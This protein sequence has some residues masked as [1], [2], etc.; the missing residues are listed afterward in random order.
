MTIKMWSPTKEDDKAFEEWIDSQ[1]DP[2]DYWPGGM[3]ELPEVDDPESDSIPEWVEKALLAVPIEELLQEQKALDTDPDPSPKPGARRLRR[4][5][6][7]GEGAAK[8]GWGTDG[9]YMR[10]VSHLGKYVTDPKG[11]CNVYHQAALG[12]PPG[13]GH[14]DGEGDDMETR[15]RVPEEMKDL[16]AKSSE[17]ADRMEVKK[18]RRVRTRAGA[19][20]YK[21]PI[22]SVI[23]RDAVMS[24]LK[25]EKPV[26]DGFDTVTGSNGKK[27]DLGKDD[28]G[29]WT[30][31]HHDSNRK[32]AVA[33]SEED[34]F[35]AVN[36]K[37]GR[38]GSRRASKVPVESSPNTPR[39]GSGKVP[40]SSRAARE[41]RA[42]R[43]PIGN[44]SG[45]QMARDENRREGTASL[46]SGL[47]GD[48]K[49]ASSYAGEKASLNLPDGRRLNIAESMNDEGYDV[50]IDNPKN[51]D[52]EML[53]EGVSKARAKGVAKSH[54]PKSSSSASS[55]S[56]RRAQG[57]LDSTLEASNIRI[58]MHARGIGMNRLQAMSDEDVDA[59]AKDT[60]AS[61]ATVRS[62]MRSE[63]RRRL[64][65]QK[66][67]A[68]ERVSSA[69]APVRRAKEK[70]D[71]ASFKRN[72]KKGDKVT[73]KNSTASDARTQDAVIARVGK[74][75][76][77][78]TDAE[79][80]QYV[81]VNIFEDRSSFTVYEEDFARW[82]L[83]PR[84]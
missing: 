51:D 14:K 28:A 77:V 72:M 40:S 62:V 50:F 57:N 19:A 46:H 2:S 4:Y 75:K 12:A 6:T 16:L 31:F 38:S 20:W 55:S 39:D 5:W 9:D 7:R 83:R 59:L 73:I 61:K 17:L 18:I 81:V 34:L 56:A 25:I 8:I 11:L 54:L 35:E 45:H 66:P 84:D 3:E 70:F 21:Q 42:T 36:E 71:M 80:Q 15:V 33:D 79:P 23:V 10:C 63:I 41:P 48:W 64:R 22:G 65:E 52:F 82:G 74:R 78:S 32:F 44:T 68:R 24:N 26:F 37:L 76:R 1:A 67:T 30:A 13:H 60:G 58:A 49:D 69:T 43:G 47:D 53:A 29:K 27:Y